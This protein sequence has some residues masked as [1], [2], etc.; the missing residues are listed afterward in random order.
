MAGKQFPL[1]RRA[2]PAHAHHHPG[3]IVAELKRLRRAAGD[4]AGVG[5]IAELR[6]TAAEVEAVTVTEVRLTEHAQ[7]VHDTETRR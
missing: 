4:L 5:R 3:Q 7:A 1:H 6:I 2:T